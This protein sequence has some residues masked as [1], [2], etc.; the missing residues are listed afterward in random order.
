MTRA[1][2]QQLVP[3]GKKAVTSDHT[4]IVPPVEAESARIAVQKLGDKIKQG[5]FM[6]GYQTM[7]P[8]YKKR[9]ESLHGVAKLKTQFQNA[10]GELLKLGVTI[11]DF[12]AKHPTGYFRVWPKI[13]DEVKAKIKRGEQQKTKAGD[14]YYHWL[15]IVP[16]TQTWS[17]LSQR[18]GKTRYL[19]RNEF[20]I[21]IAKVAE[22]PG[23]EQWSFISSEIKEQQI[24]S[25]FPSIPQTIA[26]PKLRDLE[27]DST[28]MEIKTP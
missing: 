28:G 12:T 19:Q 26:L 15:M 18:G 22:I 9:Q 23:Q 1:T 8:R 5:D 17:F 25:I 4:L 6:Y 14:I 21:A 3:V 7:Y 13:K 20:Q 27:V 11:K 2:A 16:T 10:G 24:R